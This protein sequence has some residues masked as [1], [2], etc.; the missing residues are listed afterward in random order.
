MK[1]KPTRLMLRTDQAALVVDKDG[2]VSF[3]LP[4][5]PAEEELPRLFQLLA[6]IT[7]KTDDDEWVE[8]TIA[9][10]EKAGSPLH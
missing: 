9:A 8:Q 6:A 4:D 10:A 3:Y 2:G 1:G 5:W 7:A